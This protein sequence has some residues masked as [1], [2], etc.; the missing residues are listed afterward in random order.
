MMSH[1]QEWQGSYG[2]EY[3]ATDGQVRSATRQTKQSKTNNKNTQTKKPHTKQNQPINE[4]KRE[5]Q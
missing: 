2:L 4:V 5:E 1:E 3:F